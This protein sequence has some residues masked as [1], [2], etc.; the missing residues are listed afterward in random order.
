MKFRLSRFWSV[1]VL[2]SVCT[3]LLSS[4]FAF[5]ESSGKEARQNQPEDG[6]EKAKSKEEP[7][8]KPYEEVITKEA[9]ADEGVFTLQKL[10]E[11]LYYEIPESELGSD[12]LWVSRIAKTSLGV[13]YGGQKLGTRVVRWERHGDEILLRNISYSV[14]ADENLPISLAVASSNNDTIIKKFDIKAFGPDGQSVVDVTSLFE[15]E[16]MEFSAR[17]R[18][19]AHGFDKERSFVESAISFPENIEVRA[20]H[21]FTKPPETSGQTTRQPED[22]FL[23]RGMEPGSATV[24]MHYSMVSL[25]DEPIMPR[26]YDPRVGYFTV[27]QT[28][29]GRTEHKAVERQYITRWRLEKKDP[30]AEISEPIQPIVYWIDP[31]TPEKWR[32][33][34]KRGVEKWQEAFEMAGFKN[35]IIAKQGPTPEVDPEWHPEDARYSVIRWLPS[36]IENAMGPHVNDP[37]SGEILESDIHFYHNVQNLLRSWYFLQ[38]GPLDPRAHKLPFPDDLMGDL[39]EYVVAHEVGHTLG[40]RH[41]MKASSLYP[42]EKIRDREWVSEMSHTPTLMDYSRFNYVAQP[43]DNIEVGDL[44]PKIG[45]YDKWATMWGYKPIPEAD[46][47]D[48]EL[49]TL[50]RWALEQDQTIYLQFS[51]EG[52]DG[53]DPGELTEAVGDIDAVQ[54]TRLGLKN[55]ERVSE[56]MLAATSEEAKDWDDLEEIYGRMLGQWVREMNHVAALVGG[57]N[58]RQRHA[59]QDGVRFLIVPRERQEEALSFL[60]EN[61]LQTPIFMIQ[62][63]ILRRIEPEGVLS[64]INSSQRS[65]LNSLLSTSRFE[66]L[67]EQGAIDGEKAYPAEEFLSD[68]RQG[69]WSEVYSAPKEIDAFR[70]NLHRSY[71][72]VIDSRLNGTGAK[73]SDLRAFLR[74]ELNQLKSDIGAAISGFGDDPSRYHLDDVLTEISRILDPK[75]PKPS[76]STS[77]QSSRGVGSD[78]RDGTQTCWPDLIIRPE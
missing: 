55:L 38:V 40:F 76:G 42:L 9:E 74:G 44:I 47:P 75:F 37:R 24:L 35:G 53:S 64:R 66:R 18:L 15:T 59:G 73:S 25:P 6:A 65:V 50:N 71:L 70:R 54:A 52:T 19:R 57:F 20:T 49:K 62:P 3:L 61:A 13:G 77:G 33:F 5:Q 69:I 41:N 72:D 26:L 23:G 46:S 68:L 43:E 30:E 14:V 32:P 28:D 78:Y 16:V 11:K 17:S 29:Y 2:S 8:I 63:E 56:L 7:K 58:S 21:T 4:A 48:D 36:D 22:P 67:T 34:V 27:T 1:V 51:T 60:I 10:K 45:P 12:F 31:A 39:I